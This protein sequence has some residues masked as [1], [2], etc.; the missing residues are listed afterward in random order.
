MNINLYPW[1]IGPWK[2]LQSKRGRMPHGLLILGPQGVGK[3]QLA[4]LF[5]QSLLCESAGAEGVPC[6]TCPGCRWIAA[7]SHPDYRRVEPE[8]L[9]RQ[10]VSVE[11]AEA[12]APSRTAKPSQEIKVD[13]IDQ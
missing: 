6:G 12:P 4:E 13:Q 11:D 5:A 7:G 9:A 2:A 10:P 1:L 3:L 8:A